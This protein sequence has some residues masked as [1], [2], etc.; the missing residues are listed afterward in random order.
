MDNTRWGM[1]RAVGPFGHS[2]LFGL[3]FVML[4]PLVWALRHQRGAWGRLAYPL[5]AMAIVGALSSMSSGPWVAVMAVIF[6]LAMA[7]FKHCVKPILIFFV[8]SCIFV[9]FAS[10]RHFYH[11]LANR[12]A[13]TGGTWYQRAR[14]IDHSIEDFGEWWLAGY[15]GRDPGWDRG[16]NDGRTDLNNWFLLAA[17]QCGIWGLIARCGVFAVAIRS[18]LRLHRSTND[19]VLRSWIWS[20]GT[21]LVGVIVAAIAVSLFDQT[22]TLLHCILG[23]VGSSSHLREVPQL[24]SSNKVSIPKIA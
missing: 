22:L 5:S 18:L 3:C 10:N 20:L 11:V 21:A 24:N 17:V 16:F 13:F 12:I 15:R 6:C 4:L 8:L 23:I 9:E 1:T 14:L 19:V 7:K 2:I